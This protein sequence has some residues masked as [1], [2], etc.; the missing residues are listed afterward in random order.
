VLPG[1]GY[2]IEVDG[3]LKSEFVTIE[4]AT[5]GARELKTRFPMLQIRIYDAATKTRTAITAWWRSGIG[6]I[7]CA[8][9]RTLP[10][11]G[12]STGTE[13]KRRLQDDAGCVQQQIPILI[14]RRS[15]TSGCRGNL[16]P[17]ISRADVPR[18][19]RGLWER[20]LRGFYFFVAGTI[21]SKSELIFQ[22]SV[23]CW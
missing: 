9:F 23:C 22:F 16:K 17:T 10:A 11:F 21:L 8:C 5:N 3:L 18:H 20:G 19:G 13:R 2:G 7:E 1:S 4:G 14:G 15:G 12:I 6:R